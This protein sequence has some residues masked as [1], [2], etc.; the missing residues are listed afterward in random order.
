MKLTREQYRELFAKLPK[1]IQEFCTSSEQSEKIFALAE[2]HHLH[3][4]EAGILHDIVM[5]TVM[6]II[7]T[8][9]LETEI[10][11]ALHLSLLDAST[12]VRDINDTVFEP[13]K[14]ILVETYKHE[15]PF[16]PQTLIHIHEEDEEDETRLNP[17]DLLA[18]IE[19]P[20]KATVRKVIQG[21]KKTEEPL[22]AQ[23]TITT[24]PEPTVE[25]SPLT[26]E[27]KTLGEKILSH[28][29][30]EKL[31]N[32]VTMHS[33][34]EKAPVEVIPKKEAPIEQAIT[35]KQETTPLPETQVTPTNAPEKKIDP[36]REAI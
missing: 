6:G 34:I 5:D 25:T 2:K 10:S 21:E 35:P 26:N 14:H 27:L 23:E 22:V 12:I 11:S 17:K 29:D 19:N 8:K 7:A 13:I 30:N 4:D 15:S 9:N 3:I 36:Y 32:I 31:T 20:T 28:I 16:K 18:E 33:F 1:E 24:S